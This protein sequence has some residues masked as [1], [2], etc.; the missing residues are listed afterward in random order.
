MQ[1]SHQ[2]ASRNAPENMAAVYPQI[3]RHRFGQF[4]GGD[5]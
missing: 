2:N 1:R 5:I 4:F 3:I